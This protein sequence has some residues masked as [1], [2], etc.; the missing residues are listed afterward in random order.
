M[1]WTGFAANVEFMT[2]VLILIKVWIW[3]SD[4]VSFYANGHK[5]PKKQKNNKNTKQNKNNQQ[6]YSLHYSTAE[7]VFSEIIYFSFLLPFFW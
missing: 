6:K 4:N 3:E 2:F 5:D 1:F 7:R